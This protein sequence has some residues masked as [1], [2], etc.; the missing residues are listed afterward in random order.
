MRK[1]LID[2]AIGNAAGR[3]TIHRFNIKVDQ[4]KA[5]SSVCCVATVVSPLRCDC[6]ALCVH[7]RML[8]EREAL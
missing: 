1:I 5:G 4:A 7:R 8:R 6:V 2:A 3:T